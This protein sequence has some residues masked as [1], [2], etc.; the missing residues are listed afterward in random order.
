MIPII[1][2]A[3]P[4]YQKWGFKYTIKSKRGIDMT[5]NLEYAIRYW[6]WHCGI[7][8]KICFKK[9]KRN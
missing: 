5:T 8:S 1:Y 9:W 7:S 6:L 3:E 4:L 2:K